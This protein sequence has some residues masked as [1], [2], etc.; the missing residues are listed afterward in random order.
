MLKKAR[1]FAAVVTVAAVLS[2]GFGVGVHG[3]A[4]KQLPHLYNFDDSAGK[5]SDP[6]Q[7]SGFIT[8]DSAYAEVTDLDDDIHGK[9]VKVMPPVGEHTIQCNIGNLFQTG[10]GKKLSFSAAMKTDGKRIQEINLRGN[11]KDTQLIDFQPNKGNQSFGYYGRWNLGDGKFDDK[12]YARRVKE[13]NLTPNMWYYLNF[14][15]SPD[16]GDFQVILVN[17]LG[18]KKGGDLNYGEYGRYRADEV[19]GP[20]NFVEFKTKGGNIGEGTLLLDDIAVAEFDPAFARVMKHNLGNTEAVSPV[21]KTL[22]FTYSSGFM[23]GDAEPSAEKVHITE[24]SGDKQIPYTAFGFSSTPNGI[25]LRLGQELKANTTY[26]ITYDDTLTTVFGQKLPPVE[27]TTGA[28]YTGSDGNAVF[29]DFEEQ[30]SGQEVDASWTAAEGTNTNFTKANTKIART[31][32]TNA[33]HVTVGAGQQYWLKSPGMNSESFYDKVLVTLAVKPNAARERQLFLV[34]G[35]PQHYDSAFLRIKEDGGL[36]YNG[37][38]DTEDAVKWRYFVNVSKGQWNYITAL[39][40]QKNHSYRMLVL[41]ADGKVRGV[42]EMGRTHANFVN[43]LYQMSLWMSA[44]N[45]QEDCYYDGFTFSDYTEEAHPVRTVLDGK[46]LS[47]TYGTYFMDGKYPN[48]DKMR[49]VKTEFGMIRTVPFTANVT[50]QGIQITMAENPSPHARYRLEF[51]DAQTVFGQSLAAYEFSSGKTA[52]AVLENVTIKDAENKLCADWNAVPAN[53]KTIEIL[54]QKG[55]GQET[56]GMAEL[57]KDGEPVSV[58]KQYDAELCKQVLTFAP[59]EPL[60]DYVLRAGSSEIYFRTKAVT[61]RQ[62]IFVKKNGVVIESLEDVKPGEV[63]TV[64]CVVYSDSGCAQ[65]AICAAA[66]YGEQQLLEI[67]TRDAGL[68]EGSSERNTEFNLT[69]PQTVD[70]LNELSLKVMLLENPD[71]LRPLLPAKVLSGIPGAGR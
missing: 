29:M 22:E 54:Y 69:V 9:I 67:K 68:L 40:D 42:T 53:A 45:A 39:V 56:A 24:I 12:Q 59:L 58:E 36:F 48:P 65:Q 14:Q 26:Q 51:R 7:W 57:L 50:L 52:D 15:I 2:G 11:G 71:S 62:E 66:L 10:Q 55:T 60:S 5:L 34:D 44:Q 13:W 63:L 16:T 49:L 6:G 28:V 23:K 20:I 27:F 47:L 21:Q 70:S 43:G 30:I 8:D 31:D 1:K 64:S 35:L 46:N 38:S 4:M 25:Q 19:K 32:D 33:M 3:A 18:E 37:I 41:G 61:A 17:E